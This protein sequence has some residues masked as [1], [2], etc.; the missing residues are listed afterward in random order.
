MIKQL[1]TYW[2]ILIRSAHTEVKQRYAGSILGLLWAFIYP[3]VLFLIYSMMYLV[4]FRVR[5]TDMT[6]NAYVVY[7]L[8]GLIPFLGFSESLI[9]GSASITTNKAILL[10]TVYPIEFIPLQIVLSS[11]V[12][13]IVGLS[14]LLIAKAILLGSFSWFI[15]LTPVLILVQIMF[16]SGIVWILSILNLVIKDIQTALTFITILLMIMSPIAY[17][18]SM[19]PR[20]LKPIIWLNPF[21]YLVRSFQDIF[22]FNTVSYN[23]LVAV[24][25][26]I[27]SYSIG[28][29]FFK[30]AKLVFADYA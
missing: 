24:V 10:N 27:I 19:V 23:L 7:I 16:V 1:A 4:I 3:L 17:T 12:T 28:Y 2:H 14:I 20:M 25:L 30:R 22:V 13:M 6:T 21:S 5:P 29:I 8:S 15:L 26:S 11:H 18:P 9:S